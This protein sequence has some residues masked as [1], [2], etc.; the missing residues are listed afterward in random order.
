ML[1]YNVPRYK[2]RSGHVTGETS[3]FMLPARQILVIA[4]EAARAAVETLPS[5]FRLPE[6]SNDEAIELYVREPARALSHLPV[7]F[8]PSIR[9]LKLRVS[10]SSD[11]HISLSLQAQ[12]ASPQQASADAPLLTAAL[13][14]LAPF[15]ELMLT[16]EAA[17]ISGQCELD[18]GRLSDALE[19]LAPAPP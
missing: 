4:P 8:P 17:R 1:E 15:R 2:V 9:W 5:N 10:T 19:A 16:A 11:E 12:D 14:Q 6:P 13:N 18:A 7:A 3:A